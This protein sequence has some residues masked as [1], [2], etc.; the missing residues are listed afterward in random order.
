MPREPFRRDAAAMV[1]FLLTQDFH[2]WGRVN[3]SRVREAYAAACVVVDELDRIESGEPPREEARPKLPANPADP[4]TR[5]PQH[6]RGPGE[7]VPIPPS[8]AGPTSEAPPKS[9]RS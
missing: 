5:V 8:H 6:V 1:P 2:T 4:S 3:P 7:Q 9:K